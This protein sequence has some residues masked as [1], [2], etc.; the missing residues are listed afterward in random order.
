[1]L[2]AWSYSTC[3]R[4]RV[5]SKPGVLTVGHNKCSHTQGNSEITSFRKVLGAL[6]GNMAHHATAGAPASESQRACACAH[7]G[8]RMG[9]RMLC[10]ARAPM[11]HALHGVCAAR[12]RLL[13]VRACDAQ[14]RKQLGGSGLAHHCKLIAQRRRRRGRIIR[15]QRRRLVGACLLFVL[16]RVRYASSSR[17]VRVHANGAR[18]RCGA[19]VQARG[20][21]DAPGVA[22]SLY[23]GQHRCCNK[24]ETS[25]FRPA[26]ATGPQAAAC[27][28]DLSTPGDLAQKSQATL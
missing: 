15:R 18:P 24:P 8:A 5:W 14:A 3:K 25:P 10:W 11:A 19:R 22:T 7:G 6:Q 16:G 27:L 1:M 20:Q 2:D 28:F 12:S 21:S 13:L 26:A 23:V 17:C 9:P 4:K